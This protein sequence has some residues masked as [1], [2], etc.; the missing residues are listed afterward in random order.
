MTAVG[1]QLSGVLF[2]FMRFIRLLFTYVGDFS[3]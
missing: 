3:Y 2:G 1:V